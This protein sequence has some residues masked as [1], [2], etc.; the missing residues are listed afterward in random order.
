VFH[1]QV[2]PSQARYY[3]FFTQEKGCKNRRSVWH[4]YQRVP[5]LE[6]EKPELKFVEA[7][8]VTGGF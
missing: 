3:F 6:I 7:L 2:P 1:K 5:A 8:K 4:K